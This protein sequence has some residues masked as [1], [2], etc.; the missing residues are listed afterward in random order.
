MVINSARASTAIAAA[1]LIFALLACK[2]EEEAPP[3]PSATASAEPEA[4]KE[5]PKVEEKKEDEVERYGDKETKMSGTVRVLLNNLRVYKKAD[6]TTEFVATLNRGTLVNLKASYGN[7]LLIEY[8]SGYKQLSPG[9]IQARVNSPQLKTETDVKPE[10][11]EKQ[12]AGAVVNP[13]A[14]ASASAAPSA[15]ATASASASAEPSA[16]ASATASAE[17]SATASAS[18]ANPLLRRLPKLRLP[19]PATSN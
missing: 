13:S 16:T 10:D 5:E 1:G 6:T 18:P 17:P 8:P 12:D 11:V 19:T 4:P 7:Y 9:W 14:T 2:K 15:S 3:E